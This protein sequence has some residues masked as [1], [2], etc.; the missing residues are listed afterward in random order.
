MARQSEQGF[1]TVKT[2]G[3]L[4]PPELIARVADLDT[5][6]LGI[7]PEDYNLPQGERI[8]EATNRSWNRLTALWA[9]FKKELEGLQE[10][11]AATGITRDRWLLP[12]FEELGYG[13]L[14]RHH[15]FE[16]DGKG[17]AISHLWGHAPIHLVGAGLDLDKR[18]P[19]QV[20]AAQASPHGL[21]QQFLNRTDDH[22]WAFV[23][24]GLKLR[25]LHDNV[26]LT[27]QAYVELDVAAMMDGELYSD[28]RLLWL[29]CHQSRVES[30]Q[31]AQ[32]WLEKWSQEAREQGAR[33]LDHLREGVEKAISALGSGFLAH[34]ANTNLHARLASGE[35]EAQDYYRQLLRLVYRLIFLFV[36]E[37]RDLLLAGDD[38]SARQCYRDFYSTGRLRRIDHRLKGSRYE[39][40]YEGLK[41]VMAKLHEEGCPALALPALGSF[42][43]DPIKLPDL[44]AARIRNRD[45]LEAIR[46]LAFSEQQSV[47]RPI[48]YRNLGPEELGSVYESLLELHP[49]LHREAASFELKTAAGSERKTTGSYYTP[50]SLIQELLNSALDPVLDRAAAGADP[51]QAI[52]N[53]KVC[54]PAVGSGHFLV[55]A[56]HRIARRLAAVRSG[57]EEPA[58]G[59]VTLALRDVVGH[60]LYGVDINEMAVELCKVSLWMTAMAPGRPLSFL[61]HRIRCG[62]SLLGTTP[63]L[64]ATGIPDE[65]FKPI[66][67]DDKKLCSAYKAQNKKERKSR[68]GDLFRQGESTWSRLCKLSD[69]V[70]KINGI[71]D[72]DIRGVREQASVYAAVANSEECRH[73]HL[74]ANACCAAFV[75]KKH[76]DPNLPYPVTEV[77]FRRLEESPDKCPDWLRRETQ[78]LATHYQFFHWHIEFPDVF[79][80][81]DQAEKPDNTTC[82]WS[83]G[84]DVVLGNPPWERVK[85]QEKEWFAER[86]PEIAKAPNAA[87]RKRLIADL[88]DGSPDLYR[89][90]MGDSRH[91]EGASHF[92][93]NSGCFPLCGSGDIN[94]YAVFAEK[95]LSILQTD[96][97]AGFVVPSGIATDDSTKA[98][99]SRVMHGEQLA[100]LFDFENR[101]NLFP[102]IGHGRMKFSLVTLGPTSSPRFAF[103]LWKVADLLDPARTFTL[104]AHDVDLLNPNTQTCPVFRTR[105]EAE[106]TKAIYRRVPVFVREL[107]APE[108]PWHV[109][110]ERM[111]DMTNDAALFHDAASLAAEGFS[112]GGNLYKDYSGRR[113]FPLYEAKMGFHYDHRFGTFEGRTEGRE[114]TALETPTTDQHQDPQFVAL[115]RYWVSENALSQPV[116]MLTV[117]DVSHATNE[118]SLIAQIIPPAAV[119]N[120]LVVLRIPDRSNSAPLYA[121]LCS[122]VLD[123]AV[124]QKMGGLH[125]NFFVL[126]Q[127]P[128]IDPA[129][130]AAPLPWEAGANVV[131]DWILPRVLELTYTAW[132]L[133][134]FAKDCGWTGSPFRWDEARRCLIR[135]EL[136]AA[137]FHL[138]LPADEHGDWRP[139]RRADG[140]PMTRQPRS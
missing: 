61:D 129:S 77:A 43:W 137:F 45:F 11:D 68:M 87:V 140:C 97:R 126:K 36:A 92:L 8:N 5:K 134:P 62:N 139:A 25:I 98:F 109:S 21:V 34:P 24:N 3:L 94:L 81:P 10:G 105:H 80:T 48:D 47:L 86:C 37:D 75:W 72:E 118:R 135:C 57:D 124:R 119:G 65:A 133:E 16:I 131:R 35:L 93:R 18:A 89:E 78:R 46:A 49:E 123:F 112:L 20:G 104:T 41:V 53:L 64:M 73:G 110:F 69:A 115:P 136:D 83:G 67:G 29:L 74:V 26:S 84:F 27:R 52:L 12:L 127:L 71:A 58:P 6:L 22:L 95:M 56:G 9:R 1:S 122:F 4:L 7:R 125:L 63:A 42:L 17:Y 54:D 103:Q 60:C 28:F 100:C 88:K 107:T 90:F 55:A 32:C 117:R 132:D 120:S 15:A 30:E 76:R 128:V 121:T 70:S 130:F 91:A 108:N 33:A 113:F 50:E 114:S 111:F 79:R 2:E 99:F 13:R 82:G 38:E 44:A 31:P 66:E 39:D 138:Y 106:I 101:E 14:Q 85:L 116:A 59:E 96:G 102:G 19:G 40:L 51:E 23:S